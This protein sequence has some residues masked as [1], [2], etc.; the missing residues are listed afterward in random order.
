MLKRKRTADTRD[1]ATDVE[2][3]VA[4]S[5]EPTS[6]SDKVEDASAPPSKVAK[7]SDKPFRF[8]VLPAE[9]RNCIYEMVLQDS[10]VTL[11]RSPKARKTEKG[12]KNQTAVAGQHR[13]L[14]VLG[15]GEQTDQGRG[16]S[17]GH[18]VRQHPVSSHRL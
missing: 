3:N 14:L 13:G 16:L 10:S 15:T 5:A 2:A 9:L 17:H 8:L 18:G 1:G 12:K 6:P 7:K 11:R 4:A